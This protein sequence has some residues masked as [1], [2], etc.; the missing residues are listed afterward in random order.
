MRVLVKISSWSLSLAL[1]IAAGIF[2]ILRMFGYVPY[3]I[4]SDS[5]KNVYPLGSLVFVKNIPYRSIS[6]GDT[7]SFTTDKNSA[8]DTQRVV[9]VSDNGEYFYTRGDGSDSDGLTKI[10][11]KNV[12]GKVVFYVPFFGYVSVLGASSIGK[13]FLLI[14]LV[15][16]LT[17]SAANKLLSAEESINADSKTAVGT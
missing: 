8:V 3:A 10:N 16:L 7:I 13:A 5:M 15:A 14:L 2:L 12:L 11:R 9:E 4:A 6:P 17:L 1:M